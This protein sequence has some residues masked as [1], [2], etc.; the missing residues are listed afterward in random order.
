MRYC[1]F[2]GVPIPGDALY[3]QICGKKQPN[4]TVIATT[5][6]LNKPAGILAWLSLPK[7]MIIA[8]AGGFFLVLIIA[9]TIMLALLHK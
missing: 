5:E 4:D 8:G 2:C 9:T 6:E 7:N 1:I 3:C